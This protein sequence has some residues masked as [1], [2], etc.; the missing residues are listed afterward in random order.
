MPKKENVDC[1]EYGNAILKKLEYR[2]ETDDMRA[3]HYTKLGYL[4]LGYRC[5]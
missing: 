3:G 5:E 2:E 4:V 1:F